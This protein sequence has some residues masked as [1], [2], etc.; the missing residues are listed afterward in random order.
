[1]IKSIQRAMTIC[2]ALLSC[3]L[4]QAQSNPW[5]NPVTSPVVSPDGNVTFSIQAPHAKTVELEGQFMEGK[6]PMTKDDNGIWSITVKIET[7][8]IYPYSFFVNDVQVSDP[9]NILIFPNERYKASLLEMPGNALYAVNDVPHGR[10]TYCTYKSDVL[11]MHRPLIVYTPAEYE[12]SGKDY[13]VLYLVSGTTDTE[14]TWFKVGRLNTI[15]DNLIAEGKAE[16]MIVV[17]P[18]GY[19]MGGTPMPTSP[20]AAGMYGVFANEMTQCIIPFVESNYRVKAEADSRAIAGFSR[21]GGQSLFTALSH[22]DKFAWLASYSAHLTPQV[23]DTHFGQYMENPALLNKGLKLLWF[24]VGTDDFLYQDVVRNLEHFNRKKITY[25][26]LITE[27]G[28]T[29]MNARTYL[30]ETLQLFFK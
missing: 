26:S 1:M 11:N 24:G 14:E 13:P 12:T 22:L 20:S 8:D 19:M 3:A 21:G 9:S 7:P 18:Y 17:M 30:A 25:K 23:L 27:G 10:M 15:L 5:N 6:K 16:P 29:W 2:L 4:M 28:H